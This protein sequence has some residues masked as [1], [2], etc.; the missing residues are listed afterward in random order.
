MTI[1][2]EQIPMR[3]DDVNEIL[4]LPN[5]NRKVEFLKRSSVKNIWRKQ[6]YIRNNTSE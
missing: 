6:Y 2:G 5:G 1:N 4:G 3:E